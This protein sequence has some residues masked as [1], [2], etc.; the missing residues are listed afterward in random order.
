MTTTTSSNKPRAQPPPPQQQQQKP[1]RQVNWLWRNDATGYG[2]LVIRV[3]MPGG[4]WRERVYFAR[5]TRGKGG[6]VYELT[7]LTPGVNDEGEPDDGF[8]VDLVGWSCGCGAFFRANDCA[9]VRAVQSLDHNG[10]L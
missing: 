4:K 2:N 9:H 6:R 10:R 1:R 7:P 8:V 5:P 3:E